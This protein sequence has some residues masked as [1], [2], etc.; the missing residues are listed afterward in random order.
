MRSRIPIAAL[1]AWSAT[2][3]I[4]PALAAD[5]LRIGKS[6]AFAFA[7]VPIDVGLAKGFY[8]KRGLDLSVVSFE[9]A[10]KMDLAMTS[11]SIDLAVG[12]PMEM[13]AIEKGMPAIAVAAVARPIRELAVVVPSDSPIT[14]LDALRGK[15]IGIATVGSI[16]Q[17]A[18]LEL[19]RVK[20]WGNDG[21]K[22]VSIGSGASSGI[23]AMRA[24][25]VDATVGNLMTGVVME[26][27][28]QGRRIALVSDY[29]SDF[30]MHE[31][32]AS[33]A[34]VAAKPDVVRR[35]LAGWF[36]AV[37]YM[38]ANKDE[39]VRIAAPVTGLSAADESIEYDL[40][41]PE[42]TSDGRHD[43]AI[44]E[45]AAKSFVDLGIL[46]HPPDMSKLY[47]DAYLPPK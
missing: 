39:T 16:T 46:D 3:V 42:V 13:A 22:T 7:Y 9:G 4:A 28:N 18:A 6:P 24:H 43:A 41:M 34:I 44:I 5:A 33:R 11:D 14:S 1:L 23:A 31:I 32:T 47:T 17:W 10:A 2:S 21:I 40:L 20:G 25:L 29:A 35:F 30:I 26:R 12:S 37:A 45:R 8:A 27:Q 15:S 36:E 38:R 19:A